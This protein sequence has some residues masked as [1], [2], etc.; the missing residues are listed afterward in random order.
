M[1]PSD[2]AP[3][4]RPDEEILEE[5]RERRSEA[6][7]AWSDVRE[8]GRKDVLCVAGKVW[9]AMAPEELAQRK[10]NMRPARSCDEIGQYLN[11]TGNDVRQNK[12]GVKVTP[13]GNGANDKTAAF[14]Q[15]RLRQIEYE[16]NAQRDVY[17]PIFE[18]ALQRSYGYGRFVSERVSPLSKKMKLR[19]EALP[20]PDVCLVD[21]VGAMLSPDCSKIEWAFILDASRSRKG[22]KREFANAEVT[23][24]DAA[25]KIAPS[26]FKGNSVTLAEYWAIEKWLR[27]VVFLKADPDRGYLASK[28]PSV[29]RD[30]DIASEEMVEFP[31]VCQYLTNGVELLAKPGQKKRTPWPGRWIPIFSCYG[32]V[33]YVDSD[34]GTERRM[35]SMV[36]LMREPVMGLAYALTCKVETLGSVPRTTWVGYEGQFRGHTEAWT[37]AN[38]EPV[39]YLEVKPFTEATGQQHLLPLPERQSWD[40]PLQN[41][42]LACESFRRSIQA[43]AGTSPLPTEAQRQNQKSGKALDRIESSGQ[44][45]SFHHV[46][47]LDGMITRVGVM[48]VDL[49]PHYDDTVGEV[50]IRNDQDQPER[51]KIN[52]PNDADAIML[53]DDFQHDVTLSVGPAKESER[54]ASSEFADTIVGNA[55]LLQIVGPQ[56]ASKLIADAIRLKDVGPVGDSMAETIDPKPPEDGAPPTPQQVAELQ[57]AGQ[58]LQ[59]QNQELQQAIATDQAKQQASIQSAQVKAEADAVTAAAEVEMKWRIAQLEAETELEKVRMQEA[60]KLQLAEYEVRKLE[61]QAEI[62]AR[63]RALGVMQQATSEAHESTEAERARQHEAAQ[64]ERGQAHESAEAKAAR[65]ATERQAAEGRAHEAEMAAQVPV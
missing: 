36:R 48:A 16:S 52:D 49:I 65:E 40:P 38:H 6:T 45:G 31:Y 29:P 51:Q 9:E 21:P 17:S 2:N 53:S 34:G 50:T 35:L 10:L 57:A 63:E 19:I 8:E 59:Q 55:E 32:K 18:D 62:D 26:W 47:H 25:E 46:D 28:L 60:T 61:I 64:T 27:R 37:K 1:T 12:R 5:L 24:F 3:P 7:E 4:E 22:F 23:D 33:L 58:Q 14:L 41:I 44:K 56:K 11:Q 54:Q 20:N 43:A 30:V 39:P 13:I 15:G 42:E